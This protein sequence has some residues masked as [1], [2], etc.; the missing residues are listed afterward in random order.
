MPRAIIDTNVFISGLIKSVSCRK[1]IKA[2]GETKFTLVISPQILDELVGV[3]ARPKFH[4][5]ILRETAEKLIET[6]KTQAI[7]VKPAKHFDVIKNDP[8][9]NRFIE[10]AVEAKAD[11]IVSE[12]SHLLSLKTFRGISIINPRDFLCRIKE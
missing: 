10:A 2:L 12:D 8:D 4:N 7:L 1:I 5:I 11:F 9:D 6:I 3:I